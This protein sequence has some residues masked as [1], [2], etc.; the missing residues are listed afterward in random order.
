MR[1]PFSAIFLLLLASAQSGATELV[2]TPVN[3]NFGGNPLN[4]PGL[5]S[6]AQ[7]QNKYDQD[8]NAVKPNP[9]GTKTPLE[10]F[11]EQLQRTILSRIAN[12]LS[13]NLVDATGN[14][15][16]GTVQTANFTIDIVDNGNGTMTIT[17]T[18]KTTGQSTSFTV[19]S[20][21]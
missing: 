14:L 7:A 8:P 11:N 16:P 5:L 13:G 9:L 18:D 21:Y 1:R 6:N 3:P 10:Q 17:T 19:S 2:Y 20:S 12:A 15:I 4:G